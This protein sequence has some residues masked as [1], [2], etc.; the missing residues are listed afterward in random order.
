[1]AAQELRDQIR[2]AFPATQFYG[3]VTSCDCEECTHI[4]EELRHKRWDEISTTFLDFTSS[5]TLLTPEA[6]NAFLPAYLLRALDDL[7]RHS[8]FTVYCLCPDNEDG[9]SHLLQ[10]ARLM[11]PVQIQAI[12][13]FLVFVQ[14]NAGDAEWFRP[15]I[16]GALEK[17][18]Q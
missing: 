13:A 6:F 14:E 16:T 11:N 10:R 5:P 3:P 15:F 17:V 1:M 18:W 4:R 12:R 7:D 9:V 2:E 8:E